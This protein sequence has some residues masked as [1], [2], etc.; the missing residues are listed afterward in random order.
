MPLW[1]VRG[2][3]EAWHM[4]GV[5]CRSM[6][7]MLC[8]GNIYMIESLFLVTATNA[9]DESITPQTPLFM[10]T[11][12]SGCCV[13]ASV[14]PIQHHLA[15]AVHGRPLRWAERHVRSYCLGCWKAA[16]QV[17][18]KMLTAFFVISCCERIYGGC[19]FLAISS[20]LSPL[21]II[22]HWSSYEHEWDAAH[23]KYTF[24]NAALWTMH[25]I[26]WRAPWYIVGCQQVLISVPHQIW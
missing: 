17:K 22:M 9:Q 16:E 5:V 6:F 1:I 3:F 23:A 18:R 8:H 11:C 20:A 26:L 7:Q 13:D 24:S 2:D 25:D 12:L 19:S 14:P 15:Y 10:S 21:A 4:A